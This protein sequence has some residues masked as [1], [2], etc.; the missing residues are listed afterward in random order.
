MN[1]HSTFNV[2][3]CRVRC[4]QVFLRICKCENKFIVV[5]RLP[6]PGGYESRVVVAE[7]RVAEKS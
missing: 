4:S 2:G 6:G 7:A 3:R 1:Q 5:R